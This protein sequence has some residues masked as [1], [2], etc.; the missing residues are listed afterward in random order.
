[1][2]SEVKIEEE[3]RVKDNSFAIL[4]EKEDDPKLIQLI[5]GNKIQTSD[6][7]AFRHASFIN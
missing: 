3:E 6:G 5:A 1:M 2:Q 4:F 7:A